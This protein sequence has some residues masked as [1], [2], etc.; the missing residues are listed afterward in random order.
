MNKRVIQE[1]LAD[2]WETVQEQG[3][4]TRAFD[5]EEN[6]NYCLVGIRRAGKSYLL[7]QRIHELLKE[8]VSEDHILY[9]NFEDERLLEM[10]AAELHLLL[11]VQSEFAKDHKVTHVFLDELQNVTGWEKFVRRLADS[12]YHV[13]VTGSNAKMLSREIATTLGGRFM[14][15]VV[16]PYDFSEYLMALGIDG[17]PRKQLT[18]K[19]KAAISSTF[20]AYLESGAF[21]ELIDVQ[22]KR[23]YLNNIYQTIYLGDIIARNGIGNEFAVRLLLKKIAE[24]VCHP[25][26]Y[27]RLTRIVTGSGLAIGKMTVIKY[28]SYMQD[29][30][31]IFSI[32]NIMGK[33][34]DR[35]TTPKYYF[36]DTGLLQLLVLDGVTAA[37]ENLAAI[38]LVR[39]YGMD[40][41]Y[42]YE[43]NIEVDFYIP[44][45]KMAVQVCYFLHQSEETLE[46]EVGGLLKLNDFMKGQSL[47]ILTYSEEEEIERDGVTIHVLPMWKWLLEKES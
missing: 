24:S 43:R 10:T 37:L 14:M 32:Q 13:Y 25:L 2:Q 26:S 34:V 38:E 1:V 9:V 30:Y 19:G 47:Y 11:E 18:M 41:V 16:Y 35:E 46:R 12:K 23:M 44:E 5:W 27:S 21:P 7:I 4:L 8:G 22:S 17:S 28:V 31:L 36:M 3:F 15:R 39:R 42:Y 29:S 45:K 6:L 20:D 33:L 40:Q